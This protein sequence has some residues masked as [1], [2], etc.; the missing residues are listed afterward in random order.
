MKKF[1]LLTISM[2]MFS[3]QA[4]PQN[5]GTFD[6]WRSNDRTKIFTPP[7]ATD[8]LA[9][10]S[11]SQTLTNKTING[12]NNTITNIVNSAIAAAAGIDYSK[13][14]TMSTGQVL[15]G[16]AGVA[17][18]TTLSG[19]AT[20]GAT[21]VV[22]LGN[23][24]VITQ[25]LTGYTS[26]AGTV[27]SSDSV[28]SA[29]QKLNGNDA[30]A[31]PK[32]TLGAKG[33]I[34]AATGASTPSP[35]AVGS[36][37]KVL[38][39]DS[40][41]AKGLSYFKNTPIL[42]AAV[43][44]T[45][46]ED[47]ATWIRGNNATVVPGAST[48]A[49][50]G[51]LAKATG[52]ASMNGEA[53]YTL[54]QAAG[55]LNDYSCSPA[56]TVDKQYQGNTV[57]LT[58]PYLYNG[59]SGDIQVSLWDVTS[60]AAQISLNN[61]PGLPATL[62]TSTAV[63]STTIP[64]TTTSARF[65]YQVKT[66]NSAKVFAYG[67]IQLS[68]SI[69]QV[70]NL[71]N[72]SD[73][74]PYTA[75]LTNLGS[76]TQ[77]LLYK[78]MGDFIL[79]RG[80]ITITA[81]LVSGNFGVGLPPGYSASVTGYVGKASG[82]GA[83]SYVSGSVYPSTST[84]LSMTADGGTGI[85]APTIP[86]T[87]A[88]S[89]YFDLV[90]VLVPVANRTSVNPAIVLPIQQVSSDT[91]VFTQKITPLVDSD[92]IGTYNTYA[93]ASGSNTATICTTAPTQTSASMNLNGPMVTGRAYNATSTC[94]LPT[95]FFIKIGK[96]LKSISKNV[97]QIAGKINVLNTDIDT[98]LAATKSGIDFS[99][100]ESS[101]VLEVNAGLN[102][103]A[104]TTRYVGYNNSISYE[105]SG[106]VTFNASTTPSIAA[107]P[108]PQYSLL[109]AV[110]SST[111][112]VPAASASTKIVYGVKE[113]DVENLYNTSTGDFTCNK[114]M[115]IKITANF[116]ATSATGTAAAS[117]YAVM[118][119]AKGGVHQKVMTAY[120]AQV[121]TPALQRFFFGDAVVQCNAGEVLSV[122]IANPDS[123]FTGAGAIINTW[124]TYERIK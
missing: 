16:N 108:N 58:F 122:A 75:T 32:D 78:D 106:Y 31:I 100:I 25:L 96:G 40:T 114:S 87:W 24:A 2:L 82:F 86:I 119:A 28:L 1:L 66:L 36:D 79:V 6:L 69:Y 77:A 53:S 50:A 29:I 99:Y 55:S 15:L 76:A 89:N 84:S 67:N 88:T 83:G 21:G 22:T 120:T 37:G 117:N 103:G 23:S 95:V 121:T 59:L 102:V 54:T 4:F 72:N 44:F 11:S 12:S 74:T 73:L 8:T 47:L 45:G 5:Y 49:L 98:L 71:L 70:V 81:G 39:A 80:R 35:V 51:T 63:Y 68:K 3:T 17:T 62:T 92:P 64:S 56:F 97:F 107:L 20:V 14:G 46:K 43:Q 105:S 48:G 60:T 90:N 110:N 94:A 19:G 9:G 111:T 123:A 10:L 38:T 7:S 13:L 61:D 109:A 91:M 41:N 33:D 30:L 18:P 85:W 124:A 118:Y 65:C 42:D 27:S 26:G 116:V 113:L 57:Y 52:S 93:I 104:I 101:G 115:W 112:T 34:L